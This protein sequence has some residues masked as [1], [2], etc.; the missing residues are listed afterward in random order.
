MN[1][2]SGSF[3]EQFAAGSSTNIPFSHDKKT[4]SAVNSVGL[5]TLPCDTPATTLKVLESL[6][7]TET[8]KDIFDG[9]DC[10]DLVIYVGHF[11]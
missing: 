9:K 7:L 11:N 1:D 4:R 10:T 5:S 6:P 3:E 8:W 2:F